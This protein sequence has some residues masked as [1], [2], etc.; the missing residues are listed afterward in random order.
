[1]ANVFSVDRADPYMRAWRGQQ[2]VIGVLLMVVVVVIAVGAFTIQV[3]TDPR[4]PAPQAALELTAADG[5][6]VVT[7][8]G[9]VELDADETTVLIED[10][11]GTR[12]VS[13][14]DFAGEALE[15]GTLGTGETLR[16]DL[17]HDGRMMVTVLD[18]RSELPIAETA[19]STNAGTITIDGLSYT[20]F[21][22]TFTS[23]PNF[24]ALTPVATGATDG[25]NLHVRERNENFAFDFRGRVHVPKDG[26]YT[27]YTT[28]DDGS[29]LY[30][31]GSLVVEN[32][33]LHAA[34]E[35]SGTVS[36]SEGW[37]DLRVTHFEHTGQ[38]VLEIH[39][40]G[41]GI[42]K[43]PVPTTTTIS[44][45][46]FRD[47]A[48]VAGLQPG[49][50]YEYFESDFGGQLPDFDSLSPQRTGTTANVVLPSHREED[51]AVRYTGYVKVPTDGYYT[52]YTE[53]DDGS[54]LT[55]G[56]EQV[57]NNDGLH[58]ARE[59]SGTIGLKAGWH[60]ITVTYYENTGEE[61]LSASWKGPGLSK[62]P[63]PDAN[64]RYK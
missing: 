33:G 43:E 39:W 54:I 34:S 61:T 62:Q 42:S 9:G 56:G 26:T 20:Y 16:Q 64:L 13:L 38:E 21:E 51:F 17:S 47:P 40:E 35:E 44:T 25:P 46:T 8:Q 32:G 49:L 36:L 24:E 31:D 23:L 14:A 63:I 10:G 12:R 7:H 6:L 30:V 2:A 3:D 58:P 15:D 1:M 45:S 19:L 59:R 27:F 50:E 37:H 48:T 52:F 11:K 41:P 55:I 18:T 22:G 5:Q 28:S 53:S 4:E 60:P 57:V 29:R